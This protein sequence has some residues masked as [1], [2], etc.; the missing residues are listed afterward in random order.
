[1]Y[2]IFADITMYRQNITSTQ[3]LC[4]KGNLFS[5][6]LL[7]FFYPGPRILHKVVRD[8]YDNADSSG[9]NISSEHN[10]RPILV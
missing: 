1:M 9:Y 8:K 5:S 2:E 3:L 4:R 6:F 10:L 7:D